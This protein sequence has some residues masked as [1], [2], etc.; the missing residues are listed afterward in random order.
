MAVDLDTDRVAMVVSGGL[1]PM[2]QMQWTTTE[3]HSLAARES[4]FLNDNRMRV[5]PLPTLLRLAV[6]LEPIVEVVQTVDMVVTRKGNSLLKKKRKRTSR[7]QNK[8]SDS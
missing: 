6:R 7:P 8:R 4:V 3:R 2:I 1:T 5:H